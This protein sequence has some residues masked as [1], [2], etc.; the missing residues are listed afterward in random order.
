MKREPQMRKGIWKGHPS[1]FR[2]F[3]AASQLT[4]RAHGGRMSQSAPFS[5]TSLPYA[6]KQQH[7]SLFK[8]ILILEGLQ[9]LRCRVEEQ[10][11][12]YQPAA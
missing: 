7:N 12:V 11:P 4:L 6:V 9:A 2:V 8:K 3:H 5:M 10:K 1:F